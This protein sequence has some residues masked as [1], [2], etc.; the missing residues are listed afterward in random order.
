M[1]FEAS[2]KFVAFTCVG[3]IN[4]AIHL[5]IVAGLVE[6]MQ[7]SPV[8]ANGLAFVGA[9][10]F[11]FWANSRFT[12]KATPSLGRYGRFLT[13]SLVGLAVS[14]GASALALALHWHYLV[15]VLLAFIL[16]PV[17]SYLANRHWTWG[18]H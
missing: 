5:A 1:R 13:V 10:L 14:L 3:L 4:T 17:L 6:A 8:L 2:R 7:M 11:S 16:L 9:N 18:P 12:F 15:G